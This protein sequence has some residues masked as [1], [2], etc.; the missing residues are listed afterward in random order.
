MPVWLVTLALKAGGL[1]KR[2]L[3]YILLALAMLAIAIL[4][5]RAPWAES[6][7][8]AVEVARY[9]PVMDRAATRMAKAMRALDDADRA[10]KAQNASIKAHARIEAE[11]LANAARLIA[12]ADKR[13]IGRKVQIGRLLA[14]GAKPI[15]GPS[16]D[17]L[18]E[19]KDSW[20]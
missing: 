4:I 18:D 8:R 1:L 14:A 6:R 5:W 2:F 19:V 13:D 11:R 17:S 10:I 12:A 15:A 7:G 20:K 16:C 9:Q 3:P